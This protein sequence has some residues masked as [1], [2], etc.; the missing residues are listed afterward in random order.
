MFAI[1][2]YKFNLTESYLKEDALFFCK[3][4]NNEDIAC[5]SLTTYERFF[6]YIIMSIFFYWVRLIMF[7]KKNIIRERFVVI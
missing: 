6:G 7:A 3:S 1:S 4:V 2:G 5:Y